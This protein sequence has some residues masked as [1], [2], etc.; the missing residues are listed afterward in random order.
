[1][2]DSVIYTAINLTDGF[3]QIL[4]RE[5]DI[6][7]TAVST[8]SVMLWEWLVMPQGLKN[9]PATF[10]RLVSYVLRLL[11]AFAPSYFDG[12]FVHSRAED[13]LSAVD[14]H[15]RHLRKVFEKMRK[16]KLYGNLKKCVFLRRKFRC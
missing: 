11:R 2:S 14:V 10:N 4:M 9:A 7:L 15:L 1:M 16:N 6:P 13:G 12:I 3:Y 5:S 8:P